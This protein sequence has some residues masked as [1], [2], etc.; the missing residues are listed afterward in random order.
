MSTRRIDID[1]WLSRYPFPVFLETVRKRVDE[2]EQAHPDY[3]VN[4]RT[5]WWQNLAAEASEAALRGA[6][7][8]VASYYSG[9]LQHARDTLAADGSPLYTSVE[10]AIGGRTEILG[11]PVV[12]DD[13]VHAARAHYT[14]GGELTSMPMTLSTMMLYTNM[15]LLRAAGIDEVPRTWADVDIACKAISRLDPAVHGIAWVND[16]KLFQ[17][18]LC[19]QG[20]LFANEHNGR[21]GRATTVDLTCDGVMAYVDW[22]HRLYTDG[23]FHYTGVQ[24][25][26][27]G[28]F[29]AFAGQQV[30]FRI[31]SSF[32]AK[33][34][35]QAAADN[36]FEVAISPVPH[37]GDLPLAGTWIGGDSMWLLDGLDDAT[38][39][40]ALAFMQY[41]VN[42]RSSAEWHTAYGSA[43]T[44]RAS[45]DLLERTGWFD[46]HPY[47]RAANPPLDLVGRPATQA[48]VG[49]YAH[50]QNAAMDA[51][52]EILDHG[53][54]PAA[55]FAGAGAKAQELLDGYLR[56]TLDGTRR[57][58][59]CLHVDS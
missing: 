49:V 17:Q 46:R 57:S 26:W 53:A 48:L 58:P 47:Q 19:Q 22:W 54:D 5:P 12:V 11:E 15:T 35:V 40:G 16:G 18:A 38:R 4:V 55:S 59:Y 30:V 29:E 7:P 1:V 13:L 2:F 45:I 36:G 43:P 51:M 14:V 25:D 24:Q 37:N 6:P 39:D 44:T 33:Y 3:R 9:A 52:S 31:S 27:A 50:I 32:D 28:T 8:T 21:T 41:L 42:P 56:H 23:H 20:T 34:S 10:R